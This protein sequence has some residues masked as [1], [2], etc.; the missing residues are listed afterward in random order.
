MVWVWMRRLRER[1]R[2]GPAPAFATATAASVVIFGVVFAVL[3]WLAGVGLGWLT[4]LAGSVK[5]INWL[6]RAHRGREPDQRHRRA[7]LAGQLLRRARSHAHHRHRDHRDL[8]SLAVVA[9][10][11]RRPGGADRHRAGDARRRAVRARRAALVLHLA[12]GGAVRAGAEPIGDRS[13]RGLLDVD[14]GDLQTRR[15]TRHVLLAARAAAISP[16]DRPHWRSKERKATC[17]RCWPG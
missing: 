8:T 2:L 4:A 17:G 13:D 14:H 15:L 10:S 1:R 6:T 9:V 16:R 3:S 11:P 7:V 12:A 5:I